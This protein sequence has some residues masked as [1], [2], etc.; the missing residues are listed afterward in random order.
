M[1]VRIGGQVVTLDLGKAESL[2]KPG[3]AGKRAPREDST[4]SKLPVPPK[5]KQEVDQ[6]VIG[7]LLSGP[8]AEKPAA[9]RRGTR[10]FGLTYS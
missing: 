4:G 9:E 8:A 6:S 10:E 5:P 1:E 3:A 2:E 7:S